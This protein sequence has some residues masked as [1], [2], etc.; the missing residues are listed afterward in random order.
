[1]AA[2][3]LYLSQQ[4]IVQIGLSAPQMLELTTEVLHDKQAGRTEMPPKL[5]VHPRPQSFLHAMP[6]YLERLDSVGLK[7]VS[8]YPGNSA[9]GCD[10][11]NAMMMLNDAATGQPLAIMDANWI[12]AYRT[13]TISALSCKLLCGPPPTTLG[14]IGYG[15]QASSHLDLLLN[16]FELDEVQIW[17]RNPE[18]CE[19]FARQMNDQHRSVQIKAV[20]RAEDAIRDKDLVVS[21]T[22]IG[23][24]PVQQL[25]YDWLKPGAVLCPVE[26]DSAW[27]KK[28]FQQADL[29]VTDDIDQFDQYRLKGFFKDIPTPAY[30]L[31][32]L[33]GPEAPSRQSDTIAV[34]VNLGVG[35]MDIAF[36]HE[37]YQQA[38]A[39][40]IGTHLPR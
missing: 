8:Y 29:L 21:V 20:T 1:M 6:G 17:G 12:T 23:V 34:A 24:T 32:A 22:P 19:R 18:R 13:A 35:I 5:G 28:T 26:F 16:C 25:R 14:L 10:T 31:A 36:A 39:K 40:E 33:T 3:L 2:E 38:L 37:L 27:D 4:D 11:I 9:R 15:V 30:D 7:L